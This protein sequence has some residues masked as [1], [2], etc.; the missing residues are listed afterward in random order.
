MSK[1]SSAKVLEF[2]AIS[3]EYFVLV[4]HLCFLITQCAH[5][6]QV[7]LEPLKK[8]VGST[9]APS[10]LLSS[11]STQ[12]RRS[13]LHQLGFGLGISQWIEDFQNRVSR[14]EEAVEDLH[15]EL[16]SDKEQ[17]RLIAVVRPVASSKVEIS[18]TSEVGALVPNRS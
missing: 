10:L 11:C 2:M 17:E 3:Y 4:F 7:F 5:C 14:R 13:R 6:F 18:Q 9:E 1:H 12:S 16:S 15:F 8:L